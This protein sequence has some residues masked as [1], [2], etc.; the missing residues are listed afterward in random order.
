MRRKENFR[1]IAKCN[2]IRQTGQKLIYMKSLLSAAAY[3]GLLILSAC[4]G[5]ESANLQMDKTDSSYAI[6][7]KVTGQDTG[8]IYLIHRQSG[9]VD[10]VA[11]DHGYFKL[12]GKADTA[13]F[14]RIALG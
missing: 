10:T 7:G 4:H 5:N 3:I 14:C 8:E 12:S 1:K 13:E 9:K 2:K 6:I 11:L